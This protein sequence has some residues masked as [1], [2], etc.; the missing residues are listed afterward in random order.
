MVTILSPVAVQFI[1]SS[2]YWQSDNLRSTVN[3]IISDNTPVSKKQCMSTVLHDTP[4]HIYPH[5]QYATAD[6]KSSFHNLQ[7][8]VFLSLHFYMF[9][10]TE[11]NNDQS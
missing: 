11:L 3:K 10:I 9:N 1:D 7:F 5:T 6:N 8:Q 4:Y 2:H